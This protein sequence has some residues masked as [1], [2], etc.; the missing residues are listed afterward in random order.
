MSVLS[1]VGNGKEVMAGL[2]AKKVLIFDQRS[3]SSPV[4]NYNAHKGAVLDFCKRDNHVASISD[5]KTITIFDRVAGKVL[6]SDIQVPNNDSK[7]YPVCI[8]WNEMAMYVG[9]SRGCLNLFNPQKHVHTGS[10]ELWKQPAMNFP[11]IKTK[12]CQQ[13]GTNGTMI[14]CSDRGEIKFFYNSYPPTEFTS[15]SSSTIEITEVP[16]FSHTSSL[17]K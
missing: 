9:D 16:T 12:A 10:I 13:S 17:F 2:Y 15:I 14:V 8:S 11:Q 7:A 5:D 6:K 4:Q 3:G 1:L